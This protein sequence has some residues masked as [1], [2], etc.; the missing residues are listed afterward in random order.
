ME[1]LSHKH[2]DRTSVTQNTH[3]HSYSPR[4]PESQGQ[5]DPWGLL[6]RGTCVHTHT[7][8]HTHRHTHICSQTCTDTCACTHMHTGTHTCMHTHIRAHTCTHT[9]T[10]WLTDRNFYC[11]VSLLGFN[12]LIVGSNSSFPEYSV[13]PQK[14]GNRTD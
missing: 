9:T 3:K 2:R 8:M 1:S 10:Y 5:V 11:A 4:T 12:T 13:S 6:G 14:Q 7:H